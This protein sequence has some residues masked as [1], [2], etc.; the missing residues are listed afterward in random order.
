MLPRLRVGNKRQALHE[1]AKRAAQLCPIAER[2]LMQILVKR[3]KQGT[4]G[5]G[6]GVAIPHGKVP[7]LPHMIGVFARLERPDRIRRGRWRAGRPRLP[8]AVAGG[9]NAEH[10]RALAKVAR[11]F[12]HADMRR[13]LRG[14]ESASALHALL[15]DQPIPHAA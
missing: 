8:A 15:T 11:L 9:E 1:L 14:T 5:L 4:T 10:L 3:E 6:D 13:K 7:D 12:R 2:E